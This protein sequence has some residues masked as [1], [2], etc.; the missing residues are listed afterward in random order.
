MAPFQN[1]A[2]EGG[3]DLEGQSVSQFIKLLD[4]M[5]QEHTL[6]YS[7][8]DFLY[9]YEFQNECTLI[10]ETYLAYIESLGSNKD[11]ESEIFVSRLNQFQTIVL[12]NFDILNCD[13][14]SNVSYFSLCENIFKVF[15]KLFSLKVVG[16]EFT[17]SKV[18]E[19]FDSL[20]ILSTSCKQH[21]KY[22]GPNH[23]N[24]HST[25]IY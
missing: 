24:L 3:C 8:V 20:L 16:V 13:K 14:C 2:K 5:V 11:I 12:A 18:I 21:L 15:T 1:E 7:K 6:R 9:W 23:F 10:L 25:I 22:G 19:L 4:Q 17:L